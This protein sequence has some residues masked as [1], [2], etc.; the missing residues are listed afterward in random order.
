[1]DVRK[2]NLEGVFLKLTGG[3]LRE[4]PPGEKGAG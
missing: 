4:D 3:T 2:P 1:L